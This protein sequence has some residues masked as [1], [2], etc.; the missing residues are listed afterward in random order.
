MLIILG[1]TMFY[2]KVILKEGKKFCLLQ[3]KVVIH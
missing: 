1:K 2:S 3:Q